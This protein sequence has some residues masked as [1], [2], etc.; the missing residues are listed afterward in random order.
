M[1]VKALVALA[2]LSLSTTASAGDPEED[3]KHL[4]RFVSR[5]PYGSSKD[6]WIEKYNV[7]DQWEKV[8][9]VFGFMDDYEFCDDVI[10]MYMAR[11]PTDRYRCNRAN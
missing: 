1:G 7:F 4:D 8:G 9:I 5:N 11:Y 2:L 3:I 6:Q 10:K